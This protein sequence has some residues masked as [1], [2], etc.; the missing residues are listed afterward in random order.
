M[1]C[2]GRPDSRHR[3]LIRHAERRPSNV[4]VNHSGT[5]RSG[6]ALVSG[7]LF[8]ALACRWAPARASTISARI[9]PPLFDHTPA[10]RPSNVSARAL[11]VPDAYHGGGVRVWVGSH[12]EDLGFEVGGLQLRLGCLDLVGRRFAFERE[13]DAAAGT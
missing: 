3:S 7:P 10:W 1:G 12:N 6:D 5:F 8:C 11:T 9:S 4:G 13:D 2:Y